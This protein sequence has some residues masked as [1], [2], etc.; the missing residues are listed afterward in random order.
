MKTDA[1]RLEEANKRERE[2]L[3][4]EQFAPHYT[5][6]GISG[7]LRRLADARWKGHECAVPCVELKD[8]ADKLDAAW[9][10]AEVEL[11]EADAKMLLREYAAAPDD[12]LTPSAL[13][14]KRELLA[15]TPNAGDAAAMREALEVVQ[16]SINC[17]DL[18][19]GVISP[20]AVYAVESALS[21]PPRNCDRT[22]DAAEETFEKQFGR[23]WT[24]EEDELATWLFAKAE[25]AE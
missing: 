22:K 16:K 24:V 12:T 13:A 4:D 15:L 21:K 2:L 18:Y 3:E 25:G 6:P 10:R 17:C 14:L 5:V 11:R 1:D 23:P 9:K 19:R 7:Q 8:I 20:L